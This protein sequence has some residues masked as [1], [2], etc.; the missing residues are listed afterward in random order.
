MLNVR[1]GNGFDFHRIESGSGIHLAGVFVECPYKII[2][3]SDGDI[4]LHT[5][6]DAILGA[7]AKGDIGTLFPDIDPKWKGATSST[8][9]D[10][11]LELMQEA[12][13]R[14]S[15]VDVTI[16]CENPKIK[17]MREKLVQNLEKLMSLQSGQVSLKATTTEKMGFL[18]RGE[19]IGCFV[20]VCLIGL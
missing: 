3:H 5:I 1:I 16:I 2:A 9:L 6:V 11:A 14:I 4:I 13:F 12:G 17:P 10:K 19:G 7:I 18:G 15:N 20:T 8:F